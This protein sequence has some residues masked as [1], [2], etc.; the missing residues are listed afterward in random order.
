MRSHQIRY[1]TITALLGLCLNTSFA[2][3]SNFGNWLIYFGNQAINNKWNWYNEVQVR[4]YNF[5]GDLEQ[6]VLRTGIGYNLTENNN[7]VLLGF[8]YIYA[9]PYVPNTD[10]KTSDNTYTIYQQFITR[11]NFGRVFILHRYRIEERFLPDVFRMRFRYFLSF[12]IPV[13]GKTMSAKTMYVS[14]YNEIF[15]NDEKPVFNQD[16]VYGAVGWVIN[17]NLRTELGVMTQIFENRNKSQLQI[18]FYNNIP[19]KKNEQ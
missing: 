16:R 10:Q 9:E 18:V 14:A 6:L 1:L 5:I 7:N 13:T 19:F 15:L 4:N 2:Q 11:Q 17:K 8:A 12:N 3:K